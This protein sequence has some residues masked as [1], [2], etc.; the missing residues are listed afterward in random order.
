[1]LPG[2]ARG[3]ELDIS[4]ADDGQGGEGAAVVIAAYLVS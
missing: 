3:P 1:M 2:A 4:G